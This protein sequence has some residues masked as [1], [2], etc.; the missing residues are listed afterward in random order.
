MTPVA[1]T[2]M[3][4]SLTFQFIASAKSPLTGSR[5]STCAFLDLVKTDMVQSTARLRLRVI[6]HDNGGQ[7]RLTW[8]LPYGTEPLDPTIL[9]EELIDN[10]VVGQRSYSQQVSIE[11]FFPETYF[12]DVRI[13]KGATIHFYGGIQGVNGSGDGDDVLVQVTTNSLHIVQPTPWPKL[14]A[15]GLTPT[16]TLQHSAGGQNELQTIDLEIKADDA[17]NGTLF[18]SLPESMQLV[19]GSMTEWVDISRGKTQHFTIVVRPL[20]ARTY[21]LSAAVKDPSGKL[22]LGSQR[23]LTLKVTE[24]GVEV[25]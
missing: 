3:P 15:W 2:P 24:Q 21:I 23:V 12:L 19:D 18:W 10:G 5:S 13:P 22:L 14:S 8:G 11:R 6:T 9:W 1:R 7:G 17:L 16:L 4:S 20:Q 25:F